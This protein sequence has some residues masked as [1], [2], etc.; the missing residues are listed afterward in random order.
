MQMNCNFI[1]QI[2]IHAFSVFIINICQATIGHEGRKILCGN[3]EE[4]ETNFLL[5]WKT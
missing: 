5:G 4:S 1:D 3:S 2:L